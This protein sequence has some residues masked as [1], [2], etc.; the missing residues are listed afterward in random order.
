MHT[1]SDD[2][3][4]TAAHGYQLSLSAFFFFF[5]FFYIKTAQTKKTLVSDEASADQIFPK[6]WSEVVKTMP[7]EPMQIFPLR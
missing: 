1:T 4:A 5:P 7:A 3:P 6:L 2:I